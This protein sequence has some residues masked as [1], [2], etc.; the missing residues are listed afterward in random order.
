M[1]YT[2]IIEDT[3]EEEII[4]KSNTHKAIFDKIKELIEEEENNQ[5]LIGYKDEE[6]VILNLL[7]V[8]CFVCECNKVYALLDNKKYQV[9]S[10]LYQIEEKLT[11]K[12]IKINQSCIVNI[13]HI[14]KFKTMYNGFLQI[15]LKN[16]HVEYV[17]RSNLK[18]VKERFGIR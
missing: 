8:S 7:D 2:L 5:Q 12:Y 17:S 13:D 16:N 9:K 1:K 4:I 14:V 3:L 6:I 10:R 18:L 15:V 11:D